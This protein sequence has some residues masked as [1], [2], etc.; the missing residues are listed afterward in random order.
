MLSGGSPEFLFGFVKGL[1]RGVW[2]GIRDPLQAIWLVVVGLNKVTE[3]LDA[4]AMQALRPA[5]AAAGPAPAAASAVA[6]G[7]VTA[8]RGGTV[9]EV[10]TMSAPSPE[11]AADIGR[12]ATALAAELKPSIDVVVGQFWAAVEEYFSGS[13]NTSLEEVIDRLGDAWTA[14]Q[15][16]IE[17][18][19]GSLADRATQL[20]SSE[21]GEGDVGET[22]GWLAGMIGFQ[23]LLD[24]LSGGGWAAAGP[25]IQKIARF[26]NWP[27]ELMGEAFKLLSRLGRWIVDGVKSLGRMTARAVGGGRCGQSWRR[28]NASV[29]ASSD[30][31]R[32]PSDTQRDARP[33]SSPNGKQPTS[34]RAGHRR[35]WPARANGC[36]PPPRDRRCWAPRPSTTRRWPHRCGPAV[37]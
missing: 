10:H 19:G 17:E 25:V 35:P 33:P 20:F 7:T 14:L 15:G 12:R 37:T 21:K 28:W 1:L 9:D 30:W 18:A 32:A 31:S 34:P 4:L 29:S 2:E 5:S 13:G 11:A 36:W 23:V 6:S 8:G 16:T 27:M 26:L 24:F 3:Y 22:V